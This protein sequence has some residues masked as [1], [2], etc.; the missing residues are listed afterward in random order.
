M[1]NKAAVLSAFSLQSSACFSHHE[2]HE[3]LE[4]KIRENL[5]NLWK[6]ICGNLRNL[7][8]C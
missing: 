5:C 3:E 4:E 1:V 8:S 6:K 2:E 7:S